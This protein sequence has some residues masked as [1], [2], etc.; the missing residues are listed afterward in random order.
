MF[1]VIFLI[2]NMAN[3]TCV[4]HSPKDMV[5]ESL[6]ECEQTAAF[7]NSQLDVEGN[8]EMRV[9]HQCVEWESPN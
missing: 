1:S 9:D 5:F 7:L 6:Q 8:P 4:N 2:C 3:S